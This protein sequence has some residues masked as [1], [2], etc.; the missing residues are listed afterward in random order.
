VPSGLPSRVILIAWHSTD[1]IALSRALFNPPHQS[2]RHSSRDEHMKFDHDYL[3]RYLGAE[4]G[5]TRVADRRL[6]P[7]PFLL[8]A[9]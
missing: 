5:R 1:Q 4:V 2:T 8:A 6:Q 3:A 7:D 9:T